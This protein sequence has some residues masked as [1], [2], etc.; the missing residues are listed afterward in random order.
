MLTVADSTVYFVAA[1]VVIVAGPSE[2]PAPSADIAAFVVSCFG[3]PIAPDTLEFAEVPAVSVPG[4][5]VA[6]VVAVSAVA[7]CSVDFEPLVHLLCVF[8][9]L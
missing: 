4:I 7:G 5:A 1:T 9:L 3:T 8:L 6:G 2:F